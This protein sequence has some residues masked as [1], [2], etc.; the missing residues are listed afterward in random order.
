LAAE[1][2]DG[3]MEESNLWQPQLLV[4]ATPHSPFEKN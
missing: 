4:S 2:L 1:E 3:N